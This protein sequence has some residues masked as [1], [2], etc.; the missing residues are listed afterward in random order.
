MVRVS[1]IDDDYYHHDEENFRLVGRRT[2]QVYRLGDAVQVGVM[3]VDLLRNEMDLFLVKQGKP[4]SAGKPKSKPER[5]PRPKPA[6]KAKAK[7]GGTEKRKTGGKSKTRVGGKPKSK[8][9]RRGK[10]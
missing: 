9:S 5:K 2:R 6:G 8:S 7:G 4:K 10:K 3:K 1:S